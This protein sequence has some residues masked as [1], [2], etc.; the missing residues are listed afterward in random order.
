MAHRSQEGRLGTVGLF[1]LCF[2]LLELLVGSSEYRCTFVDPLRKMLAFAF[3]H[4]I[5][6]LPFLYFLFQLAHYTFALRH[7]THHGDATLLL[8][9]RHRVLD[10]GLYRDVVTVHVAVQCVEVKAVVFT[11]QERCKHLPELCLVDCWFDIHGGHSEQLLARIAELADC[12]LVHVAEAQCHG[13]KDKCAIISRI[14][15]AHCHAHGLF[16]VHALADITHG[17]RDQRAILRFHRT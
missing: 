14:Q 16:C 13:I 5:S 10:G 17:S 12:T 8:R 11:S 6:R 4:Q 2:G 9:G 3:D 1:G 15:H 7:V